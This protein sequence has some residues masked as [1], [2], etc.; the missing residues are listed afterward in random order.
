M[1][2]RCPHCETLYDIDEATLASVNYT[3]VCCQCHQVFNAKNSIVSK[4]PLGSLPADYA[5]EQPSVP[6]D[7]TPET[8][9]E[10]GI[11]PAPEPRED[12]WAFVQ[13]KGI[14]GGHKL[15][16][17]PTT[18]IPEDFTSLAAAELPAHH[19]GKPRQPRSKPGPMVTAGVLTLALLATAQLAWINKKEL[20]EYPKARQLMQIVCDLAACELEQQKAIDKFVI[21]HRNLQ[22]SISHPHAFSFTLSFANDADFSQPLPMLQLSLL[23][24]MDLLLAQRRFSPD[25]YL[26]PAA[27]NDRSIKPQEIINVELLLQDQAL[28]VS[29]FKLEIL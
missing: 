12:D 2:T 1:K 15:A 29:S 18:D 7:E 8:K 13:Q 16:P 19:F 5:Q 6:G 23:D 24:H 25:E 21:L 28:K 4:E 22:P 9:I 14:K 20:L 3:A 27:G 10:H 17:S 26:Y 11:P